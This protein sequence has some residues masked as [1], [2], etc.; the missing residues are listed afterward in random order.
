MRELRKVAWGESVARPY[1]AVVRGLTAAR[2]GG[3]DF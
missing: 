1:V 3:A 2:G